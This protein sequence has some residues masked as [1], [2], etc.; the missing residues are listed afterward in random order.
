M[1]KIRNAAAYILWIA[2]V[3]LFS[4][5]NVYANQDEIVEFNLGYSNICYGVCSIEMMS[6]TAGVEIRYTTNGDR[7]TTNSVLYTAPIEITNLT[8]FKARAFD[9]NGLPLGP[10]A[11]GNFLVQHPNATQATQVYGW[12]DN[13]M[14]HVTIPAGLGNT[15][16]VS[17]GASHALALNID[18]TVT[19]WGAAD[20]DQLV[21]PAGLDNV[22]EV[23]AG[24]NFSLALKNDGTVVG[25]GSNSEGQLN[26]PA[27]LDDVVAIAAGGT[28]SVALR[29]NGT[30]VAWGSFFGHETNVPADI[31]DAIAIIAG[32]GFSA[33]IDSDRSRVIGWGSA[34]NG[35]SHWLISSLNNPF[36]AISG[37]NG[38]ILM[39]RANGSIT[40]E[41]SDSQGQGTP[42][43]ALTDVVE[44]AAGYMYSMART[45]NGTVVGWGDNTAGQ[46]NFPPDMEH[47]VQLSAHGSNGLAL[48]SPGALVAPTFDGVH[49]SITPGSILTN[50]THL[51][52]SADDPDAQIYYTTNG[53]RP[54]MDG[55]TSQ[56][57]T[58]PFL[59][60]KTTRV[61]A[62]AYDASGNRGP[63]SFAN[64]AFDTQ[65]F[66]WGNNDYGQLDN[67]AAL[68]NDVVM[69]A[70]GDRH[71]VALHADGTVTGLGNND[72]GQIDF[73]AGL[74]N[75][76]EISAGGVMSMLL[77]DDGTT[78][79]FGYDDFFNP[80]VNLWTDIVN[81][82]ISAGSAGGI[83]ENGNLSYVHPSASGE[84]AVGVNAANAIA[85]D[86]GF[87]G[88]V[89][90]KEDG[91]LGV[92]WSGLD[93]LHTFPAGLDDVIAVTA[94]D[95]HALALKSD[96]SIVGWGSNDYGQLN[97]PADLPPASMISTSTYT[98]HALV[99]EH[100]IYTWGSPAD[101][102]GV[103]P[104]TVGYIHSLVSG[105]NFTVVISGSAP[106]SPPPGHAIDWSLDLTASQ[107]GF[108]DKN[109]RI[110]TAPTATDGYDPGL[111]IFAPPFPPFDVFEVRIFDDAEAESYYHSFRPTTQAATTWQFLSQAAGGSFLLEWDP[112]Q[113][114]DAPGQ[115]YLIIF[116]TNGPVI[117]NL[118]DAS[119]YTL[120][121]DVSDFFIIHMLAPA[122]DP[123][124]VFYLAP[125]ALVGHPVNDP[126][127]DPYQVF[128]N[129]VPDSFYGYNYGY[130][131]E[132]GLYPGQGYWIRFTQDTAVTFEA[133]FLTDVEIQLNEGWNLISGPARTIEES[134]ISDPQNA[135]IPGTLTG[136]SNGYFMSTLVE[137]GR[138]YW[139]RASEDATIT[140]SVPLGAIL[141]PGLVPT[142]ASAPLA[143]LPGFAR[144]TVT[145]SDQPTG[146][147]FYLG[148]S[149]DGLDVNP[150]S[151]SLP[152]LPPSNAFDV[153][154]FG[155][156][157]LMEAD[158]A[159]LRVQRPAEILNIAYEG[160]ETDNT[161]LRLLV[162]RQQGATEEIILEAGDQV[163]LTGAG[164]SSILTELIIPT[165]AGESDLDLPDRLMLGQ[166]YPNPFNPSTNI[167]YALPV[168]AE[169]RLEVFNVQGQRVAVLV[170]AHQQAGTH[171]ISFD[172]SRLA[173]GVYL[174]R[175]SAAGQIL[176][177]KMTL[178]K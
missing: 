64:Y 81:I 128:P 177:Q 72:F 102:Q 154:F 106:S 175:L 129:T 29:A 105:Q 119:Q 145:A 68:G 2:L 71:L 14:G 178:I 36:M 57:Y 135:I 162:V 21:V 23:S 90:L 25:W 92:E 97:I 37:N 56:H 61:K 94:Y 67:L 138:G 131:P 20:L 63:V 96:G 147:T 9:M 107:T 58:G 60:N 112:A 117:A 148:G 124:D 99:G 169:V 93:N 156:T 77:F 53:D 139:L 39:L 130:V 118:R 7:P 44:I 86:A 109:L 1:E 50:P 4:Y 110:G 43:A 22:V 16:A 115:F 75:V 176:T 10:V 51:I 160:T 11:F 45:S 132:T 136:Y 82:A 3:C 120:P 152:P 98:S 24:W 31:T 12:G 18:G 87:N 146:M 33:A 104:N 54:A 161:R 88:V 134:A 143:L 108:T 84:P 103:Q 122:I 30:V 113:I 158:A 163:E 59:I 27:G 173:S 171:L 78:Q 55:I 150:L 35:S 83:S 140:M 26:I 89:L 32:G 168:A 73:P 167:S 133:P 49:F 40:H 172:A 17:L 142:S 91:T 155:D 121:G 174:Y 125:W 170:E 5:Q 62:V 47:V 52:L 34:L 116:L 127:A 126:G 69:L 85:I 70:A 38:H 141:P 80:L 13:N 79:T 95:N 48:S 153:R 157:R 65:V 66:G 114:I 100:S 137:P 42:P 6:P 111:D 46:Y 15:V 19:A 144:F 165:S 151:F 101:G 8:R 159:E 74:Q 76:V 41:G 166:N 149:L 123:F 164:I 28:H